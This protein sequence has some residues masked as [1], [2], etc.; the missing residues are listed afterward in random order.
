MPWAWHKLYW[1]GWALLLLLALLLLQIRNLFGLWSVLVTGAT[2]FL[3][4]HLVRQLLD[5]GHDV[6]ALCRAES[7]GQGVDRAV[8]SARRWRG[9]NV[10]LR[11]FAARPGWLGLFRIHDRFGPLAE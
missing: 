11:Q 10:Q 5:A 2:G 7:A 9:G 1:A 8:S 6:R 4:D 3:G